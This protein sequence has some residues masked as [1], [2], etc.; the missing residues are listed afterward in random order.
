MVLN[1]QCP[2]IQMFWGDTKDSQ[3]TQK[4]IKSVLQQYKSVQTVPSHF[5]IDFKTFQFDS[6]FHG[7]SCVQISISMHQKED[8][9]YLR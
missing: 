6:W 2:L 9:Y 8:I 5:C 7:E 1:Q 3:D 4:S